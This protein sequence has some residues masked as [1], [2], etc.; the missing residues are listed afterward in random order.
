MRLFK[1][2]CVCVHARVCVYACVRARVCVCVCVCVRAWWASG[3]QRCGSDSFVCADAE[4]QQFP[5]SVPQRVQGDACA[6]AA[7]SV[8]RFRFI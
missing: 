7:A 4:H 6:I 2:V 3:G 1:Y 5:P 8:L